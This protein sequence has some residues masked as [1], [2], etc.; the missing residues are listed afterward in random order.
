L[1]AG[2]GRVT[3]L[4]KISTGSSPSQNKYPLATNS[5]CRFLIGHVKKKVIRFKEKFNTALN[6]LPIKITK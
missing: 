6:I 1:I 5:P 2:M 4:E 3:M